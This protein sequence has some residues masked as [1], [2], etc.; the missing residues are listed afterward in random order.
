MFNKSGNKLTVPFPVDDEGFTGRECP[1]PD[2][3]GYFKIV[4][5]TGLKGT[6]H[7]YCP[8]CGHKD[9][10]DKF[11]TKDQVAYLQSVL[12]NYMMG[13]VHTMF[14]D[15]ERKHPKG[16]KSGFW[17][18]AGQ[19][20]N[21]PIRHYREKQLETQ[22][23]CSTCTL[24]YAVYGV[25]A[26]C[27]DCGTHNSQQILTKNLELAKKELDLSATVEG[28]MVDYLINDALENVVS[29]FDGFGREV[30]RLY[31][32]LSSDPTH[33]QDIRFQNLVG[34]QKN[35]KKYFGFDIIVGVSSSEWDTVIRCFQKRHL[36]SHSMGVID[37]DYIAKAN[38]PT[39]IKGRKVSVTTTEVTDL[40]VF[41]EKLGSYILAEMKRLVG[42]T[43][44]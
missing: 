25:F 29:A 17:V 30:C 38:D 18:E 31:A 4:F 43:S 23:E 42:N 6:T 7:C 37:D 24:K 13:E 44:P 36:L 16:R 33:A 41:V 8:Y 32:H 5:G 22:I 3:E 11:Y 14:K 2:C 28:E 20:P 15:L 39:A 40:I 27:P 34:A 26:Y 35:T 12:K 1:N 21:V 19:K 9:E 10:Q